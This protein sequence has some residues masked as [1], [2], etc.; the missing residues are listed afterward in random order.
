M[1]VLDLWLPDQAG[2]LDLLTQISGLPADAND[3]F[4][5]GPGSQVTDVAPPPGDTRSFV[6]LRVGQHVVNGVFGLGA[7]DMAPA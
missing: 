1:L 2:P 6:R 4:W 3:E 7:D 5:A